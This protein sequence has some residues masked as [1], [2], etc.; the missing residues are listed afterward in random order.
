MKIIL[1]E[2]LYNNIWDKI[3]KEFNFT[4]S[5]DINV[6][7]FK[8]KINYKV[9]K[10]QSVWNEEQEKIVN[11]ILKEMSNEDI[12]ALSYQHDCF[13][14]NPSEEIGLEYNYYDDIR[15]CVVYFPS[16]YPNGEY[17]FFISKDFSYGFLGHP[18]RKEIYIFGD[19]LIN[20][21]KNQ[22]ENLNIY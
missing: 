7:P 4:P 18:W 11:N 20:K 19:I 12:Y 6:E 3:N 10:L 22:K 13:E 21:F 2:K 17:N 15:N 14:F 9:Y 5:I 8:F 1:D 16:C